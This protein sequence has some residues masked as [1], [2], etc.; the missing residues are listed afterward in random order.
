M[1]EQAKAL[2]PIWR[3]NSETSREIDYGEIKAI[4][5]EIYSPKVLYNV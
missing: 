3:R 4:Y 1:L 2:L 5:V